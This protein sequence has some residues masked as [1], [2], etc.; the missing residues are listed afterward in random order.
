ML[1]KNLNLLRIFIAFLVIFLFNLPAYTS[2]IELT[3][4][5]FSLN[6]KSVKSVTSGNINNDGKADLAVLSE[7]LVILL[8]GDGS[9]GFPN[10]KAIPGNDTAT[11]IYLD[12]INNDNF[13]DLLVLDPN[14]G[15]NVYVNDGHEEYSDS[16][17]FNIGENPNGLIAKDFN[18]DGW[19]DLLVV[20]QRI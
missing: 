12:D 2:S 14:K 7:G 10:T 18:K 16:K 9:G 8:L 3:R 15:L 6:A 11:K 19:I 13:D 17:V 4:A 1:K 5:S 20:A